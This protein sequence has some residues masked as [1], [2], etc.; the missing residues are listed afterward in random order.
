MPTA[1]LGLEIPM[2]PSVLS[3]DPMNK[4][5][6][7]GKRPFGNDPITAITNYT[8]QF[9]DFPGA[10]LLMPTIVESATLQTELAHEPV[11][12]HSIPGD[13]FLL[14]FVTSKL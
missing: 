14:T 8:R 4:V 6:V 5:K 1:H 3:L 12:D 11:R 9:K 13:E 10:G 2:V 7:P